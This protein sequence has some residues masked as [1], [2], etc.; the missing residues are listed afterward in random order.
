M[1]MGLAM[2]RDAWFLLLADLQQGNLSAKDSKER[3]LV[4]GKDEYKHGQRSGKA[5]S[6]LA[7]F[8]LCYSR[9]FIQ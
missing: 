1:L 6:K 9:H 4:S 8:G 7:V 5:A 3:M 2:G